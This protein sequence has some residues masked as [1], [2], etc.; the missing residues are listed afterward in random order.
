MWLSRKVQRQEKDIGTQKGRVTIS[1]P[2]RIETGS[3]VSERNIG[4]CQP[5]GYSARPPVDRRYLSFS[6]QTDRL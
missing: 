1:S 5:Y 2:E 6:L 4:L 3:T